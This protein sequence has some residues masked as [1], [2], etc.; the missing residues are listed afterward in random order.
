ME[1]LPYS[2]YLRYLTW[3]FLLTVLT[4]PLRFIEERAPQKLERE[5]KNL[6]ILILSKKKELS[7]FSTCVYCS[8]P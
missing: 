8:S 3:R 7:M 5:G 4:A 6:R 2:T 1:V